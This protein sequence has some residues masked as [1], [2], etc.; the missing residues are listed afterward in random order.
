[1]KN[2][3]DIIF[4]ICYKIYRDIRYKGETIMF[5]DYGLIKVEGRDVKI[6]KLKKYLDI[7]NDKENDII[8]KQNEYLSQ[9]IG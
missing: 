9:L 8:K 5:D 3:I 6:D 4:S 2:L 1:M 7:C